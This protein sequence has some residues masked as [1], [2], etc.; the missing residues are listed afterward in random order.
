MLKVQIMYIFVI[1]GG[2]LAVQSIANIKY[3]PSP[4]AAGQWAT[5]EMKSSKEQFKIKYSITGTEL[6]DGKTYYWFETRIDMENQ[7]NI[8]KMLMAMEDSEPKRII[9]KSNKEPAIDMTDTFKR[10]MQMTENHGK[11]LIHSEEDILKGYI[12]IESVT[13]PAG[14][15]QSIKSRATEQSG[16][17]FTEIWVSEKIP[18]IGMV[19]ASG[20]DN[21]LVLTAYGTSGAKTDITE[22]PQKF[23]IPALPMFEQ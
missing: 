21:S 14:T 1:L 9:M 10:N 12:G 19:K 20:K 2:L 5:Y 6:V 7:T 11:P 3:N 22:T 4:W 23:E 16:V 13:V 18:V 17:E 8:I 15:F